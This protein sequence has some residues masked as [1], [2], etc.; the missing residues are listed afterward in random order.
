MRRQQS[1]DMLLDLGIQYPTG[2]RKMGPAL[3]QVKWHF[4]DVR[5]QA[6]DSGTRVKVSTEQL[7]RDSRTLTS[8]V[9]CPRQGT[10][11][12]AQTQ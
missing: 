3:Q 11:F 6:E 2:A 8:S 5:G 4:V 9:I 7:R 12:E 1:K 10:S